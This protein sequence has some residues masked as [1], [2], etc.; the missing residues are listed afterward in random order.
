MVR[1]R[2]AKYSRSNR[3]GKQPD[4]EKHGRPRVLGLSKVW[5]T[6]ETRGTEEA[7]GLGR[8]AG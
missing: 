8:D 7:R 6:G 1:Q 3:A 4:K 2:A 5:R